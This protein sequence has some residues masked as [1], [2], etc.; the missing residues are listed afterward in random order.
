MK[1]KPFHFLGIALLALALAPSPAPAQTLGASTVVAPAPFPGY[2]E[3]IAVR[4]NRFYVAGPAAF[5]QPL[6]SA[7]VNAYDI[8][9]G[10]LEAVYPITI[11]NPF[12]GMSGASCVAFGADGA[13][14]AIEPFIGIIR[15]SLNPKNEQSVYSAFIPAGPSLLNDLAFDAAGNLYVTDSFAAKIYRIPPCGGAPSV[16]FSDPRLAGDPA[17]PFGVN[18]IRIDKPSQ[19]IYVTVTAQNGSLD[20]VVYRIP[21]IDN[22]V[23]SDLQEFHRYPFVFGFPPVL[24]GPDGIAF[25]KSGKLYVALAGTRQISVLRPD[26]A[27]E[28]RYSGPAGSLPWANPANIAFDDHT[29]SL[30]VTNHASLVPFDPNLFVVFNVFVD[31]K[32][33]PLDR[34]STRLNSSH[35]YI[36]HAVF[37]LEK[38]TKLLED[39]GGPLSALT[40]PAPRRELTPP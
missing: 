3:G 12:A 13:L 22:P 40:G 27:E 11:T 1:T 38:T 37:C 8:G 19:T 30:L 10:A 25:G 35:G 15:M 31:D 20:G 16:W 6:G 32:G 33:Q 39:L 28:A 9:T 7:Y 14:Y 34:K 23:A 2:P 36:S 18:G 5:G 29:R 24:P 17:L 26:G 4:G 21:A